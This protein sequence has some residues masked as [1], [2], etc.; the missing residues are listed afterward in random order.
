MARVLITIPDKL[1]KQV[2]RRAKAEYE[3]RSGYIREKLHEDRESISGPFTAVYQKRKNWYIGWVEELPGVNTQGKTLR[4]TKDNL[5][6]ALSLI[7][8]VNRAIA[9]QE[10]SG[11]VIREPLISR[12]K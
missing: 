11:K 9:R 7:L 12:A 1:L 6:D 3:T 4:E 10:T 8:A 2:D 5:K